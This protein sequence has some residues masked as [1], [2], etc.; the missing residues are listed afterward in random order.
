MLSGWR[1]DFLPDGSAMSSYRLVSGFRR[2]GG[3]ARLAGLQVPFLFGTRY[4]KITSDVHPF[5]A[6]VTGSGKYAGRQEKAA[7]LTLQTAQQ[8]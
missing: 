4:S 8:C 7:L 2:A 5:P 6:D 3:M 1:A